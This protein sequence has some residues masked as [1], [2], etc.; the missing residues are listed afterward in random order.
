[1]NRRLDEFKRKVMEHYL[2]NKRVFAWRN[3]T[4]PYLILVSEVM[5]QQTQTSRVEQKFESFIV[6]FPTV[7]SLANASIPEVLKEWQG[8]GYNRRGLNLKRAAEEIVVNHNGLVPQDPELLDSLPGIGPY[9]AR[10]VCAFAYNMPSAFIETNIRTV[11]IHE[12][13]KGKE[14]V[15][16][17]EILELVEQTLDRKN[18]R[19]W[20]YALMDYGVHLKKEH[21][22][23]N[24]Q[25][26]HYSRQSTFEGSNRQVRSHVL[27]ALLKH[28]PCNIRELVTL[29]SFEKERVE[30]ALK[31]LMREGFVVREKNSFFIKQK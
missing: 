10:A 28:G 2:A 31:E 18:P 15:H 13:F 26:K 24:K 11:F 19:E 14:K 21:G 12:F 5:L 6:R 25:S 4:D 9:T 22:N 1:M 16:D 20:Y 17:K 30:K 3:I 7:N 23:A 27:Q 8:L 29:A